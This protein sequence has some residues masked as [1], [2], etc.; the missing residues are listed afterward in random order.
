MA[1]WWLCGA[2]LSAQ[3]AESLLL[4]PRG[5]QTTLRRLAVAQTEEVIVVAE[6]PSFKEEKPFKLKEEEP[7][8]IIEQKVT[9]KGAI[10]FKKYADLEYSVWI[11]PELPRPPLLDGTHAGDRGFDPLGIVQDKKDLFNMM[12]AEVRHARLAMLC[13]AGWP[14]SELHP[15]FGGWF[16]A[17]NGRA[18]SVLNGHFFDSPTFAVVLGFFAVL[19]LREKDNLTRPKR[20]T[21]YGHVHAADYAAIE[22]EWPY[23]VP[24]DENFDPLGLYGL[25]GNDALGRFVLRDLELA[26]GRVAMLAVLAYVLLEATTHTPVVKLTPFLFN[27]F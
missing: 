23:G 16:L 14:L 8:A 13:A 6:E 27:N 19:A 26:H 20:Q 5:Q 2:L 21:L 18:P 25:L 22:E 9:E 7:P 24:G 1:R 4:S 11:F 3:L 10:N 12:E 17:S 15:W